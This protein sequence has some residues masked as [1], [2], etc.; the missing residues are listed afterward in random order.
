MK[1]S[2]ILSIILILLCSLTF[3]KELNVMSLE[4]TDS[5]C[6]TDFDCR[7]DSIC[8]TQYTESYITSMSV[9][10][11]TKINK[12]KEVGKEGMCAKTF[13]WLTEDYKHYFTKYKGTLELPEKITCKNETIVKYQNVTVPIKVPVEVE[14]III[15]NN[16]SLLAL[17]VLASLI[18]EYFAINLYKDKKHKEKLKELEPLIQKGKQYEKIWS[19]R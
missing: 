4:W 8:I 5:Y 18:I 7:A 10:S 14:K 15:K 12:A 19:G 2:V 3:G 1:R 17:I 9:F 13:A 6:D 16:W 11:E